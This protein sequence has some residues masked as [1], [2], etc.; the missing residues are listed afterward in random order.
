MFDAKKGSRLRM[1]LAVRREINGAK[2]V[3]A[4]LSVEEGSD[5]GEGKLM[6]LEFAVLWA[7][8]VMGGGIAL[9]SVLTR[10]RETG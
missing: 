7:V 3:D 8:F 2:P 4:Q 5:L 1:D 10:Q 9:L 6:M